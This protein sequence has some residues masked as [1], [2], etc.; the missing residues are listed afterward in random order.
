MPMISAACHQ[1]IFFAIARK[2]TSCT[3][4]ARS[5]AALGYVSTLSRM[6]TSSPPAM[7]T[8]HLLSPPDISC[9]NDRSANPPCPPPPPQL[10][11]VGSPH[12]PKEVQCT[13]DPFS[14]PQ[15]RPSTP[16]VCTI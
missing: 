14:K 12:N 7:R 10:S 3:F 5:T 15:L 9:A 6:D 4:I 2:I 11:F 1:L 16:R 8:F 13:G